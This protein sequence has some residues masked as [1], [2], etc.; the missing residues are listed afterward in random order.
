MGADVDSMI[1]TSGLFAKGGRIS[2]K[3]TGVSDSIPIWASNGEFMIN[4]KDTQKNLGLLH[5]I[6]NGESFS[7]FAEGGPISS[8]GMDAVNNLPSERMRGTPS[9]IINV[10]ITGDI[11]RQTKSEIHRMLP[12]IAQGVNMHNREKGSRG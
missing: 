11:S 6:N 8:R 7:M 9:Q 10:N 2:G 12:S 1:S 4:A 3:G 5:A